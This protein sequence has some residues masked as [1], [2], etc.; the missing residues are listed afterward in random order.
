M[1]LTGFPN[2]KQQSRF[3]ENKGSGRVGRKNGERKEE[4]QG[5]KRGREE[6]G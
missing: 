5:E 2:Q 4:N 6:R 3:Q 1:K